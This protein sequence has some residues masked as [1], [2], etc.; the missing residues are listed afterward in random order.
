MADASLI[1]LYSDKLLALAANM[2]L[3]D[4]LTTP[5]GQA[6]RRSPLCGSNIEVE[7]ETKGDRIVGFH[8]DVKACAL[9][10]AA[11]SVFA[12]HAIGLTYDEVAAVR[13]QMAAMLKENGP[14]P[15]GKFEDLRYLLAA[16]DFKNRHESILLVFNATLDAFEDAEK[17]ASA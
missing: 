15:T 11:A 3:T 2:P 1:A 12:K 13:D 6:K 16:R 9:G 14:S 7:I 8:Q 17:K 4:P 10:Q 5:S